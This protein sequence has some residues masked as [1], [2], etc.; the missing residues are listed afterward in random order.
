MGGNNKPIDPRKVPVVYRPKANVRDI[1]HHQKEW[2][3]GT[4][5]G[6]S[7]PADL[8][9]RTNPKQHQEERGASTLPAPSTKKS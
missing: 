3:S 2:T 9:W 1:E 8:T 6:G 7:V 4:R 5:G